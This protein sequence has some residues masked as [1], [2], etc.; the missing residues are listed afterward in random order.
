[1]G[2]HAIRRVTEHAAESDAAERIR[3]PA[4]R[5][6]LQR[7]VADDLEER[8]VVVDVAFER[9]A[10]EVADD[11]RRP[12]ERLGPAGHPPDKVELLTELRVEF[13]IGDVAARGDVDVLEH[14]ALPLAEQLDP[15]VAGLA[16]VLPVV[17][18]DP[19]GRDA[20]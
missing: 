5:L 7:R 1:T 3:G 15:D 18:R 2:V 10:V 12:V 16:L 4:E 9:G 8:L 6:A 17:L 19:A 13:A 20:G 11:Q 14:E